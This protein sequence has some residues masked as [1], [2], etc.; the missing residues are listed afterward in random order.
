[1]KVVNLTG[2]T[3]QEYT[4][5]KTLSSSSC[6]STVVYDLYELRP[7]VGIDILFTRTFR[8]RPR[9]NYGPFRPTPNRNPKL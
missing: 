2:F 5:N 6:K 9:I 8:L 4:V 7:I 1:M 3:V